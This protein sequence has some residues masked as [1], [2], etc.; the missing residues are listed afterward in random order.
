MAKV[1]YSAVLSNPLDAVWDKIKDFTD[2]R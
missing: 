2:N 1:Y